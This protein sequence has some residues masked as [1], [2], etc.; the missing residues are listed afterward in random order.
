[1]TL[2]LVSHYF[3]TARNPELNINPSSLKLEPYYPILSQS[4]IDLQATIGSCLYKL[5]AVT[6]DKIPRGIRVWLVG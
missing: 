6:A 1:M 3:G 5:E 2:I 4:G